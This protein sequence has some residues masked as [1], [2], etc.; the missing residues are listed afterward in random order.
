MFSTPPRRPYGEIYDAATFRHAKSSRSALMPQ[1]Q[2][3]LVSAA[4]NILMP[5]DMIL[6]YHENRF[7]KGLLSSHKPM[8]FLSITS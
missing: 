7:F 4:S 6:H 5:D 8:R 3:E 1:Q 2:Y